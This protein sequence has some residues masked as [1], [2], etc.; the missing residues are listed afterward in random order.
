MTFMES[1]CDRAMFKHSANLLV[2]FPLM[3]VKFIPY[4]VAFSVYK[5]GS[6]VSGPDY[7]L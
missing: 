7:N 5:V 2:I 6:F 4:V 3:V 1:R